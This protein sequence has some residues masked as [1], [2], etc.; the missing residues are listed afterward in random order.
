M[1][2]RWKAFIAWLFGLLGLTSSTDTFRQSGAEISPAIKAKSRTRGRKHYGMKELL[3]DIDETF[4]SI[5]L[6]FSKSSWIRKG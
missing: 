4:A 2:S 6:P 1:R 5:R 3:E